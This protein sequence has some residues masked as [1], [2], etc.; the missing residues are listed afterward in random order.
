[1]R[2]YDPQRLH[3]EPLRLLNCD[4]NADPDPAIPSNADH[5]LAS[6]NNADQY[7][8]RSAPLKNLHFKSEVLLK[9]GKK[10]AIE[11]SETSDSV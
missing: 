7:R 4:L 8:S 9:G 1:M 2:I 6:K 3:F 5:D 11:P 10:T